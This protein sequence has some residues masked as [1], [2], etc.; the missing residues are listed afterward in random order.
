[1]SSI[2]IYSNVMSFFPANASSYFNRTS[3]IQSPVPRPSSEDMGKLKAENSS[4]LDKEKPVNPLNVKGLQKDR[5][6]AGELFMSNIVLPLGDAFL[7]LFPKTELGAKAL[8]DAKLN[9]YFVFKSLTMALESRVDPNKGMVLE[10]ARPLALFALR[11]VLSNLVLREP[12]LLPLVGAVRAYAT[13]SVA[14]TAFSELSKNYEAVKSGKMTQKEMAGRVVIHTVNLA[15]SLYR[16]A[17]TINSCREYFFP[18]D[19]KEEILLPL[20]DL[21]HEFRKNAIKIGSEAKSNILSKAGQSTE[22]RIDAIIASGKSLESLSPIEKQLIRAHKLNEQ[23]A[24]KERA[25]LINEHLRCALCPGVC[26]GGNLPIEDNAFK[27]CFRKISL[28]LHPDKNFNIKKKAEEASNIINNIFKS[29]KKPAISS[30]EAKLESFEVKVALL[31]AYG[32]ERALP[33]FVKEMNKALSAFD[34]TSVL[35]CLKRHLD[36]LSRDLSES[37]NRLKND[38]D[39]LNKQRLEKVNCEAQK[40]C[41]LEFVEFFKEKEKEYNSVSEDLLKMERT[42]IVVERIYK[43]FRSFLK[44]SS[45]SSWF[46]YN[47]RAW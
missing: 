17:E 9:L 12:R 30:E 37:M 26:I 31:N 36:P 19:V 3:N 44:A 5:D 46:L 18:A 25:L 35:T 34:F 11:I 42:Y 27:K 39:R 22:N 1:M 20:N 32:D 47:Q 43:K 33:A 2:N 23:S 24:L 15:C 28:E 8:I 45:G 21:P 4:P 41:A 7:N 14:S 6:A 16:T 38:F 40:S 29:S 13:F 10:N